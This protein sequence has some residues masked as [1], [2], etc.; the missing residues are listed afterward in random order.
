MTFETSYTLELVKM[1]IIMYIQVVG[2]AGRDGNNSVTILVTRKGGRQRVSASM[3]L[4]I[5]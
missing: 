1:L 5:V 4:Y 3:K 2:R